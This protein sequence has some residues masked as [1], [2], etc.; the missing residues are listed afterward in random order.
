MDAFVSG[1]QVRC[2]KNASLLLFQAQVQ[3]I[4]EWKRKRIQLFSLTRLWKV[5]EKEL[6]IYVGLDTMWCPVPDQKKAPITEVIRRVLKTEFL[7]YMSIKIRCLQVL[8]LQ[9]CYPCR[10]TCVCVANSPFELTLALD[11][12]VCM[13]SHTWAW[14]RSGANC[15][16]VSTLWS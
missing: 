16:F 14:G 1:F 9:C 11:E 8:Q 5:E 10:H 12:S 2:L 13:I 4:I 6:Q 3:D 15:W 7:M